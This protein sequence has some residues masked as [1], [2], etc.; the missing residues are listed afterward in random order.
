MRLTD[1]SFILDGKEFRVNDVTSTRLEMICEMGD[2]TVF[3]MK[4]VLYLICPENEAVDALMISPIGSVREFL[5][6]W[7]GIDEHKSW[8][9][10]LLDKLRKFF[11]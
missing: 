6:W 3:N 4:K 10:K 2:I 11:V 5:Y 7:L 9:K 1:R 8:W